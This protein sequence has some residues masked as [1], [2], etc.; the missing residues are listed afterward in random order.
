MLLSFADNPFYPVI[1]P[2]LKL[3]LLFQPYHSDLGDILGLYA[4]EQAAS[5][6]KSKLTSSGQIYNEIAEL[7]PDLIHHLHK[8]DWVFDR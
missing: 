2:G 7:R 6:G 5:G 8:P 1:V 3:I 4:L